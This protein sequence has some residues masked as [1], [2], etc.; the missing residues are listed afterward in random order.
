[1]S[2]LSPLPKPAKEVKPGWW[3]TW[4]G[5][6]SDSTGLTYICDGTGYP[7]IDRAK[8]AVRHRLLKSPGVAWRIIDPTLQAVYERQPSR[9]VWVRLL[10]FACTP[11]QWKQGR[12]EPSRHGVVKPDPY[13]IQES[14]EEVKAALAI[15]PLTLTLVIELGSESATYS[16]GPM[17][18]DGAQEII[19]LA[20][21]YGTV[22]KAELSGIPPI[23]NLI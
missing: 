3:S 12:M 18:T 17:I 20:G 15:K 7:T 14:E 1:M 19:D 16:I 5:I 13:V 10:G 23:V 6:L 4:V 11:E 22:V 2:K 9:G 8:A 21:K